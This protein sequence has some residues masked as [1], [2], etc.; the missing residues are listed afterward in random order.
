MSAGV[1]NYNY[2]LVRKAPNFKRCGCVLLTKKEEARGTLDL[3]LSL[4]NKYGFATV[5]DLYL[6]IGAQTST[7]DDFIGWTSLDGAVIKPTFDRKEYR[8][9]LPKLN[10][11]GRE[12]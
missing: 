8:L 5:Y 3:M 10:Y 12:Q 7:E 6:A 9:I 2:G 1:K 4:V 11:D